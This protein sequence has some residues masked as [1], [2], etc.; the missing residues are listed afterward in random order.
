MRLIIFICS[1]CVHAVISLALFFAARGELHN[2][3]AADLI[4]LGVAIYFGI[5]LAR[6]EGRDPTQF[7][8]NAV[9]AF[10]PAVLLVVGN[11]FSLSASF[12]WI[13]LRD[14]LP[15]FA[16]V[17]VERMSERIGIAACL[18]LSIGIICLLVSIYRNA[19]GRSGFPAA[20]QDSRSPGGGGVKVSLGRALGL[21]LGLIFV[22]AAVMAVGVVWHKVTIAEVRKDLLNEASFK[23]VAVYSLSLR[24]AQSDYESGNLR[25]FTLED[26]AVEGESEPDGDRSLS[27]SRLEWTG[28]EATG[29]ALVR[30]FVADYNRKMRGTGERAC[31]E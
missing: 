11:L 30:R 18:V 1:V 9:G 25:L 19:R 22:F 15:P 7:S 14:S 2:K 21:Q 23:D 3:F 4:L 26:T 29:A 16:P 13:W 20:A 27:V 6:H 8:M 28:D 31:R 5:R 10:V 24:L 17:P 12:F